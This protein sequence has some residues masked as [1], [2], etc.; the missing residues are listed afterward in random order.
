MVVEPPMR[1]AEVAMP[2]WCILRFGGGTG[3]M[4]LYIDVQSVDFV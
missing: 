3:L 2:Y 1:V 4:V